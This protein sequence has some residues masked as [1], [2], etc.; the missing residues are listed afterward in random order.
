MPYAQITL[1]ATPMNLWT[2]LSGGTL[3]AGV[4][5]SKIFPNLPNG[6]QRIILQGDPGNSDNVYKGEDS[7]VS[8]T[9]KG[10]TI[11]G[12]DTIFLISQQGKNSERINFWLVGGAASQ[13]VNVTVE[14]A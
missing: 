2:V 9:N 13:K 1:G 12:G 6:A 3:P 14:Y 11:Q 8:A 7:S 5:V 10:E 4:S